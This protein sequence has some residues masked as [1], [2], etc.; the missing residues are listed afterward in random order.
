MSD[1]AGNDDSEWTP[2][3]EAEMK[4]LAARR[5]RSD[6]ISKI[7]GDYLLKGYKMLST[8]CA[9]CGTILLRDRSGNL[10]CVACAEVDADNDAGKDDPARVGVSSGG[11]RGHGRDLAAMRNVV[12]SG[13]SSNDASSSE[14]Q[15]DRAAPPPAPPAAGSVP[16]DVSAEQRTSTG[17]CVNCI[18]TKGVPIPCYI[19]ILLLVPGGKTTETAQMTFVPSLDL[20]Y[21]FPC[22]H[23]FRHQM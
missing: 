10:Y 2:P 20:H 11:G 15:S 19:V 18:C 14:Q 16:K 22:V 3:S 12:L 6:K 21:F 8:S 17:L 1:L 23:S 9:E 5:E 7:M 13:S 4:V